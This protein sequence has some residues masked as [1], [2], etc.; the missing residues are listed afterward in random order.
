MIEVEI[1]DEYE[2]ET[3]KGRQLKEW[4][5]EGVFKRS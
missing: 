2:I 4:E 3:Y 1:W 5:I